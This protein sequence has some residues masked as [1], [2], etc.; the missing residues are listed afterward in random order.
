[1]TN[2]KTRAEFKIPLSFFCVGVTGFEPATTWSQTRC[3]TGLRYA[4]SEICRCA[5]FTD[6]ISIPAAKIARFGLFYNFL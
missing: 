2:K 1:M 3:A 4:P 5:G 6:R